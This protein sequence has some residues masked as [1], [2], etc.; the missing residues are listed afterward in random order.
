[1]TIVVIA[2]FLVA[3]NELVNKTCMICYNIWNKTPKNL[4]VWAAVWMGEF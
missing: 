4:V 2:H 3:K 1:M